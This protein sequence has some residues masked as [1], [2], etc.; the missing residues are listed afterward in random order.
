MDEQMRDMLGPEVKNWI[1]NWEKI[2]SLVT[3]ASLL[4]QI[5]EANVNYEVRNPLTFQALAVA[6]SLGY[7]CGI[8]VDG[9]E[10][11]WPVIYIELPTGQ[12]SWHVP[13]HT[14]SWDGHSVEEKFN[15]ID[16]YRTMVNQAVQDPAVLESM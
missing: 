12:A 15:R 7:E 9:S 8:R 4:E 10:P 13:Q 3:M 14:R 1:P 6:S 2:V 16:A 11:E 5:K